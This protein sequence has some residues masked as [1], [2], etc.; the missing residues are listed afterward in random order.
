MIQRT[1]KVGGGRQIIFHLF[2][3]HTRLPPNLLCDYLTTKG[4]ECVC[5][6]EPGGTKLGEKLRDILKDP[7]LNKR[8]SI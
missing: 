5:T 8:L 6:R 3:G 2:L 1:V 7:A 4:Y